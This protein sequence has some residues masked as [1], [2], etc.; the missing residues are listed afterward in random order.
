MGLD[1]IPTFPEIK[2]KKKKNPNGALRERSL[3]RGTSIEPVGTHGL[4]SA[5][6]SRFLVVTM[7]MGHFVLTRVAVC[8][9]V[10]KEEKKKK[11]TLPLF[12][13]LWTFHWSGESKGLTDYVRFC[14]FCVFSL[15]GCLLSSEGQYSAFQTKSREYTDYQ[16]T[17]STVVL[18]ITHYLV[19]TVRKL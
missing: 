10:R 13:P 1:S 6:V 3:E 16:G 8:H 19:N 7:F 5:A 15:H 12:S 11:T 17:C 9:S 2:L 14:L 4:R 18:C